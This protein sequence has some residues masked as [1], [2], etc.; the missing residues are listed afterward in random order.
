MDDK[1]K[2][3][4]QRM[5]DAGESE[6]NIAKVIKAYKPVKKKDQS[7]F[8][9]ETWPKGY[10]YNPS[11][12]D[13]DPQST[14]PIWQDDLIKKQEEE[15]KQQATQTKKTKQE[16]DKSKS[17]YVSDLKKEAKEVYNNVHKDNPL[18]VRKAEEEFDKKYVNDNYWT[19]DRSAA[20]RKTPKNYD[21]LEVTPEESTYGMSEPDLANKR[22]L[23][24]LAQEK[25]KPELEAAKGIEASPT[26]LAPEVPKYQFVPNEA[27]EEDDFI[28]LDKEEYNQI[29]EKYESAKNKI[30]ESPGLAYVDPKDY[31]EYESAK[32]DFVPYEVERLK[33][34]YS[35]GSALSR[36]EQQ[37][38]LD[39]DEKPYESSIADKD[40]EEYKRQKE[41]YVSMRVAS[42][43]NQDYR[44]DN[45]MSLTKSLKE[46]EALDTDYI[47]DYGIDPS[48]EQRFG[49]ITYEG[50][51]QS[52]I[53]VMNNNDL[54]GL[55]KLG[56]ELYNG[57]YNVIFD[58][59][60]LS[61]VDEGNKLI[62]AHILSTYLG[63]HKKK[64]Y[65]PVSF[66]SLD[67]IREA[68]FSSKEEYDKA[69]RKISNDLGIT[70]D[71][72]SPGSVTDYL[73]GK[74]NIGWFLDP[75][76]EEEI[77]S[78][79]YWTA[80]N[81][82]QL[83]GDAIKWYKQRLK[84]QAESFNLRGVIAADESGQID[85]YV[86]NSHELGSILDN[87]IYFV[88][89]MGEEYTK[90]LVE[91]PE[92]LSQK[93]IAK[94]EEIRQ[95]RLDEEWDKSN[96]VEKTVY[97]I[98]DGVWNDVVVGT[99]ESLANTVAARGVSAPVDLSVLKQER[100]N[101]P[102]GMDESIFGDIRNVSSAIGQVC[103]LSKAMASTAA[104][105][106]G[107]LGKTV[108]P[109][110]RMNIVASSYVMNNGRNYKNA[111]DMLDGQG[112]SE[113]DRR[114]IA[115]NVGAAQTFTES[116]IAAIFPSEFIYNPKVAQKYVE[117]VLKNIAKGKGAYT[118][119]AMLMDLS[120]GILKST[121]LQ[122]VPEEVLT[123]IVNQKLINK[124][125]N[126][127]I[128]REVFDENY[129]EEDF[130]ETVIMTAF[131]SGAFGA[132]GNFG[133]SKSSLSRSADYEVAKNPDKF[134]DKAK[135]MKESGKLSDSEYSTL[136]ERINKLKDL[137]ESVKDDEV[138]SEEDKMNIIHYRDVMETKMKER[139]KLGED[140]YSQ[141]KAQVIELEITQ[142]NEAINE[143]V[144]K[145][146][147]EVPTES[148]TEEAPEATEDTDTEP[149]EQPTEPSSDVTQED[150]VIKDIDIKDDNVL[151]K[152]YRKLDD[153]DNQLKDFGDETLGIGIPIVAARAAIK[154]MKAAAKVG[155]KGID[156]FNAGLE[157][158]RSTDWYKTLTDAEKKDVDANYDTYIDQGIQERKA[159]EK[160]TKLR[161]PKDKITTMS[162]EEFISSEIEKV[163]ADQEAE[164]KG[165]TVEPWTDIQD[166]LARKK[167]GK[168]YDD[169]SY[170][171]SIK[172]EAESYAE[173][174]MLDS[175][176]KEVKES[177]QS[178]FPDL[179]GEYVNDVYKAA[180]ESSIESMPEKKVDFFN[181]AKKFRKK[182]KTEKAKSFKAGEQKG[183]QE[184]KV[185]EDIK[186][187]AIDML[188][189]ASKGV[190]SD[191]KSTRTVDFRKMMKGVKN[192]KTFEDVEALLDTAVDIFTKQEKANILDKINKELD[193]R[194][195]EKSVGGKSKGDKFTFKDIA[196]VNKIS[197]YS[198]MDSVEAGEKSD[199]IFNKVDAFDKEKAESGTT[200]QLEKQIR[201]EMQGVSKSEREA[202]YDYAM[203]TW[204]NTGLTPGMIEDVEALQFADLE[205]Q[206][207]S[208]LNKRLEDLKDFTS[209]AREAKK[210]ENKKKS[211]KIKNDAQ[212]VKEA[213][214]GNRKLI[215]SPETQKTKDRRF[216]KQ[217]FDALNPNNYLNKIEGLNGLMNQINRTKDKDALKFVADTVRKSRRAKESGLIESFAEV[218]KAK[219]DIF[220]N[221]RKA[222]QKMNKPQGFKPKDADYFTGLEGREID[223]RGLTGDEIAQLWLLSQQPDSRLKLEKDNKYTD[224][225]FESLDN[226][227]AENPKVAEYATWYK[228]EFLPNYYNKVNDV[229]KEVYGINMPYSS[230]YVP[231]DVE[232]GDQTS[233][234]T[235]G[236]YSGNGL[237]TLTGRVKNRRPNGQPIAIKGMEA[238]MYGYINDMEHF[239]AFEEPLRQ[240]Q[241][242]FGNKDVRKAI[243]QRN[244]DRANKLI[245]DIF[246]DLQ[247]DSARTGTRTME[248]VI[249]LKNK[250]VVA[251]LALNLPSALSQLTSIPAYAARVNTAR[252]VQNAVPT[253][254]MIKDLVD[255]SRSDFIKS[256]MD[257]GWDRDAAAEMAK[258]HKKAFSLGSKFSVDK[259]M[260]LTKWGD[261]GAIL[262]G[263]TPLYR[264]KYKEYI[265]KGMPVDKAKEKAYTDFI[266][267]TEEAQQSSYVENM[268]AFQRDKGAGNLLTTY[269]S[270]PMMYFQQTRDAVRNIQRGR[271]DINDMKRL[272]MYNATLPL[273]FTFFKGA[274]DMHEDEEDQEDAVKNILMG[275]INGMP[276]IAP[277][278]NYGVD[279]LLLNKPYGAP[280]PP[281]IDRFLT[282]FEKGS[283]IMNKKEVSQEE[284]VQDIFFP[285]MESFTGIP[286]KNIKKLTYDNYMRAQGE[287]EYDNIFNWLGY[288]DYKTIGDAEKKS[289]PKK[290]S[291]KP[292]SPYSSSGKSAY[293]KSGGSAYSK[294]G[295]SAYSK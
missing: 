254:S 69:M 111:Y 109:T 82:A 133:L 32:K 210:L 233:G 250:G 67:E 21:G 179:R 269:M 84:K 24:F 284:V 204:E 173:N 107:M 76:N 261:A 33:H 272:I 101:T 98:L 123:D 166:Q 147:S 78:E 12:F 263:G 225:I 209:A 260:F 132:A 174:I 201:K 45:L 7:G 6:A 253:P 170:Y 60:T 15:K 195:Y 30:D 163:K 9:S 182:I 34:K 277:V 114:R 118:N 106:S 85:G 218:T 120:K 200:K 198:K 236:A 283:R 122:E 36:D 252:Y 89:R 83:M 159:A 64:A 217:I 230:D 293:S 188:T 71:V 42:E 2:Q 81:D 87:A 282:A 96:V 105:K 10:H 266:N 137:N 251:T 56:A 191:P 234:T 164:F 62:A 31:N 259:L 193:P 126:D 276:F 3:I 110:S 75:Q 268:S 237:G 131:A 65:K 291:K 270:S 155:S 151:D 153:W 247:R 220:G 158:I 241:R 211:D 246:E 275:P 238:S 189:N 289:K 20:F 175:T 231:M 280:K 127:M 240:L 160:Q 50:D 157:A 140:A 242:V 63:Y 29:K 92:I 273:L 265:K 288:S 187:N 279:K 150:V 256:R 44:Y 165:E 70:K 26:T 181:E 281:G 129:T 97:S 58:P 28:S 11:R 183:K 292:R 8:D 86:R 43:V 51:N 135:K 16:F 258:D 278:A 4:V 136:T 38:L 224:E 274:F 115:A 68:G 219:K 205:N 287:K 143:I 53:D 294:S 121:M 207:L 285:I 113:S 194:K 192:A 77:T 168:I 221:Q 176:P 52:V 243:T 197:D 190:F 148:T 202:Y 144:S 124:T 47:L 267:A 55:S 216:S 257:T 100:G 212:K 178:K 172:G 80:E 248:A 264:T 125:A 90:S 208:E 213:A 72:S 99:A 222:S 37:F 61:P 130:A 286:L 228:N 49:D 41:E 141:K 79:D 48:I 134:L 290:K 239:I 74:K 184:A 116:A 232:K 17:T 23:D 145:Y 66:M 104:F 103:T 88:D 146:D 108:S 142:A 117:P 35:K 57:S 95:L 54:L 227:A 93:R 177:I 226:W 94:E 171:E 39:N 223:M 167:F 199:E 245:S 14:S 91:N 112:Y 229:F 5:I 262:A 152:V 180:R 22:R 27:K 46:A 73:Y 139:S 13:S 59:K 161:T 295:K 1:L 244:G 138:L 255:L 25:H 206:S 19:L 214:L 154:G 186:K 40:S 149:T 271:G 156:V 102:V 169:A 196:T 119:K 235:I 203:S 185:V 215:N 128:G 162:K 249:K 18:I